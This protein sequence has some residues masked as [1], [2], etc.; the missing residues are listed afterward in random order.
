MKN[1]A[2]EDADYNALPV[3][4][5]TARELDRLHEYSRTLPTG[6]TIGK[7]WCRNH[8]DFKRPVRI[9]LWGDLVLSI[10]W[11]PLWVLGEYVD[12]PNPDLVG[13][14]WRRIELSDA[15]TS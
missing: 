13:I 2:D 7:R 3:V 11:P 10:P 8:R 6:K 15:T 9:T 4:K 12:D 1:V 5:M 14:L